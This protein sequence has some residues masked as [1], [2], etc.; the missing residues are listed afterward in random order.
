MIYRNM[1]TLL[2]VLMMLLGAAMIVVTLTHGAFGVGIVLGLLF[3]AAGA[4]RLWLL[5]GRAR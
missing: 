1:V 5:H 3:I 2:A 4:G